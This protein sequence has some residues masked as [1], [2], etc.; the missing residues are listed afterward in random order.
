LCQIILGGDIC[1][2]SLYDEHFCRHH[3]ALNGL[4]ILIIE[5]GKLPLGYQYYDH[6]DFYSK[7]KRA[8]NDIVTISNKKVQVELTPPPRR[9][10]FLT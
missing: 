8:L 10:F 5:K 4:F 9:F 2:S 3:W 1:V 6:S 7:K